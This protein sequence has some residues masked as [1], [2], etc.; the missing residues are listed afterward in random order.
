MSAHRDSRSRLTRRQWT[1][2]VVAAVPLAAQVTTTTTPPAGAPA[3]AKPAATPQERA[4]KAY[5]DIHETSDLLSKIEVP[6]N[7]EP[8][9]S[10][11]A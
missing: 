4:R 7:V 11:R 6:M 9:F 10:F 5:A 2:L 8:A 1:A 3:P